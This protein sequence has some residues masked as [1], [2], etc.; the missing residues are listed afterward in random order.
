M[1][2]P[3]FLSNEQSQV[4]DSLVEA[5]SG[6]GRYKLGI[7]TKVIAG[8]LGN[9]SWTGVASHT[10]GEAFESADGVVAIGGVDRTG[11]DTAKAILVDA[12]G[13]LVPKIRPSGGT[14]TERSGTITTGGVSQQIMAAN[15]DRK[16]LLIQNISDIDMWFRFGATGAAADTVDNWKLPAGGS[17]TM[18]GSFVSTQAIQI[19]GA[20][21][22]KKFSAVEG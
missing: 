2:A 10:D 1:A 5:D 6:T 13:Y 7:G 15:A 16:Y 14:L 21:T 20:T 18:E 9:A 12:D 4:V 19:I 11:T 22:G 3:T 8:S 17:F